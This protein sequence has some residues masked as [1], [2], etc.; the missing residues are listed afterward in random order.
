MLCLL[1][2]ACNDE[3]SDEEIVAPIVYQYDIPQGFPSMDIPK[4][5]RPSKQRITLGKKLFFDSIL[6]KTKDISCGSCHQQHLAFADEV[7]ISKGVHERQGERNSPS[8]MNIGYHYA[9]FSDG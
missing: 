4:D 5:N 3:K 6:S 2:S 9:F 7:A 8:L 1:F